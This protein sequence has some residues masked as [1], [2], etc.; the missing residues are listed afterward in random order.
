M[1]VASIFLATEQSEV[2]LANNLGFHA[3]IFK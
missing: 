1:P 3:E 2:Q